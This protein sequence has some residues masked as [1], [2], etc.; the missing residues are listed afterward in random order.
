[1]DCISAQSGQRQSAVNQFLQK[2][3]IRETLQQHHNVASNHSFFIHSFIYSIDSFTDTAESL[4]N[5][6]I[7]MFSFIMALDGALSHRWGSPSL[8]SA[9]WCPAYSLGL[10]GPDIT[11]TY[12][13]R[14]RLP[15]QWSVVYLLTMFKC[16]IENLRFRP[17]LFLP[18]GSEHRGKKKHQTK[19]EPAAKSAASADTRP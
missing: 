15:R 4:T 5:R 3:W 1:M 7:L 10:W 2:W 17:M 11:L 13:E 14:K 8:F 9:C 18:Q 12:S 19:N 16:F 6:V